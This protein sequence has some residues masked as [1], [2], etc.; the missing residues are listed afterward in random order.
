MNKLLFT[1]CFAASCLRGC[2][3]HIFRDESLIVPTNAPVVCISP[4]C[5]I[6]SSCL[7]V[8]LFV[9]HTCFLTRWGGEDCLTTAEFIHRHH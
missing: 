4:P 7:S 5:V 3:I 9:Y 2:L 8:Y 1:L 6:A